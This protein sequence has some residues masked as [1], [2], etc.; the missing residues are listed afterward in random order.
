[1]LHVRRNYFINGLYA[2]EFPVDISA[3]SVLVIKY[4]SNEFQISESKFLSNEVTLHPFFPSSLNYS[5]ANL[6]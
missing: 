3:G 5:S 2:Q 6:L 4:R 1:M